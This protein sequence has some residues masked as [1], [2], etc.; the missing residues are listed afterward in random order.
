VG[1]LLYTVAGL[2]LCHRL[3]LSG[4]DRR[5]VVASTLAAAVM[6]AVL[7][8][9]RELPLPLLAAAVALATGLYV[10]LCAW[11][12][13]LAPDEVRRCVQLVTRRRAAV[14]R[15]EPV[16]RYD[17]SHLD[18][19]QRYQ[20]TTVVEC[21]DQKRFTGPIGRTIDALEKRAI[22]KVLATARKHVPFPAVLDVPCG[23]GRIT[24]LLLDQGLNV[25]GGDISPAMVEAARRKLVGYGSRVEFSHLDLEALDLPD[26]SFDLITCIRLFNHIGAAE[27]ERILAELARVTRRYVV[28]NISF[29]SA[30]Y[31]PAPYLK[32]AFGMP[33]PKALPSWADLKQRAAK[34][35]LV[36]A[37]F[38]Y[39]LR[40]LSEV[41]VLLLEKRGGRHG[42]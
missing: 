6:A 1:E 8:P 17:M 26:G 9:A 15:Y 41:V 37:D 32:R 2:V 4:L 39:E 5:A 35:G 38:A 13:A 40:F 24:E 3:G 11:W 27:Q 23:T 21:Y 7:W 31:R 20:D 25:L 12:G 14:P 29:S 30:L 33:M 28:L 34:A 18:V 42:A 36:I 22:R 19:R 16:L 10:G